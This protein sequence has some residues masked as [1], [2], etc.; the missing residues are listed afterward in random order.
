T[1]VSSEVSVVSATAGYARRLR[2]YRT[3]YS[4]ARCC[5]SAALPPLPQKKSVRPACTVP[6]TISSARSSSGPIVSL[7]RLASSA[8]SRSPE[9]KCCVV[10]EVTGGTGE[11]GVR[12]ACGSLRRRGE[13]VHGVVRARR[14][15]FGIDRRGLHRVGHERI[16]REE[17]EGALAPGAVPRKQGAQQLI[18]RVHTQRS[19]IVRVGV[20]AF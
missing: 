8:R 17:I 6:R 14:E 7:T 11:Q 12:F 20:A 16:D 1:A 3:T 10:D 15:G 19:G 13:P 4:V 18:R 2:M 9:V 5:A